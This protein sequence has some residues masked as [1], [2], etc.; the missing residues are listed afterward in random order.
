MKC[1]YCKGENLR[2]SG[3][4]NK[5]QIYHCLD[6][7]KFFTRTSRKYNGNTIIDGKKYCT[8]CGEFK[9]LDEFHLKHGKHRSSCKK[10]NQEPRTKFRYSRY[11]LNENEFLDIL[12]K[13]N[14]KCSICDNEFKNN[15]YAYIDHDHKTGNVRGL[16]CPRCNTILGFCNDDIEILKSA[17]NYLIKYNI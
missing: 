7:D 13:Q 10:C 12:I 6:C 16:L 1:V 3:V 8:K 11:N 2:K 4:R 9:L 14:Y 15:R 5:K 17:I